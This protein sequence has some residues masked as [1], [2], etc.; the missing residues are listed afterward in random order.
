MMGNSQLDSKFWAERYETGQTG[1]DTGSITTPLQT[2]MDGIE[3]K[4]LAIL[5][6]GG[7]NSHEAEH[8]HQQ[9]FKH[10]HLVDWV[11]APLDN[12]KSR[13]PSFPDKHLIK[14]DLFQHTGQYDLIIEQTFFCAI[15]PNLRKAYAEK[16][17]S[18]LRPGGKIVGLLF[19]FPLESG[20]PFGGCKEEYLEYFEPLF[21]IEHMEPCYNSIKPREGRELF[22]ELVKK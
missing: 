19:Q 8:L 3:D 13:V 4:D 17:H 6:P 5:I 16:M 14:D 20:P 11:Q 2:Y 21:Y 9:G 12:L 18:L 10:V 7:G 1:W 22:I 15:D